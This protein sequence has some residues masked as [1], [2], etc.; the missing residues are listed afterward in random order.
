[1]SNINFDC[2]NSNCSIMSQFSKMSVISIGIASSIAPPILLTYGIGQFY[3]IKIVGQELSAW[4]FSVALGI[5][6]LGLVLLKPLIGSLVDAKCFRHIKK[7]TWII[8]GSISGCISMIMLSY[9]SG[10]VPIIISW[11]ISSLSYGLVSLIYF[12]CIPIVYK[13]DDFGKVAGLVSGLIPIIIMIISAIVF[14][15][16]A[17]CSLNQKVLI[18]VSIQLLLI[19]FIS[20][21][22]E[23][24]SEDS[25]PINSCNQRDSKVTHVSLL[26]LFYRKNPDFYWVLLSR[27]CINM[28]TAGLSVMTLFYISRFSLDEESIFKV[29]ATTSAGVSLMVAFSIIFGYFSDKTKKRKIFIIISSLAIGW[30]MI[31][32]AIADSILAIIIVSFIYQSFVG[33]FNAV[34]LALVNQVLSSKESYARD[35]AIMNT[36]NNVAQVLVSFLTP[37]LLYCGTALMRDDGYTFFFLSLAIF[38]FLSAAFICR[39]KTP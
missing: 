37:L 33:M 20:I 7:T 13:K 16:C 8:I 30:C 5:V 31:F 25:H 34:D 15:L 4:W 9:S 38:S 19:F 21:F 22:F 27:T 3:I 18:V 36:T 17:S 23:M 1:M 28:V 14:G 26:F 32:Y 2:E 39:V 10:I 35:I 12:I 11:T 6:N 24:P 29:N